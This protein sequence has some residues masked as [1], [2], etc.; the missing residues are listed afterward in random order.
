MATEA[1]K[2]QPNIISAELCKCTECQMYASLL[3]WIYFAYCCFAQAYEI[4]QAKAKKKMKKIID[5]RRLNMYLK[6][7]SV[8]RL[9]SI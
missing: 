1:I 2:I 9:S 6:L 7:I 3:A 5:V 8:T 4:K